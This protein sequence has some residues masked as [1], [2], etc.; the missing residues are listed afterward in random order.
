[1]GVI[2]HIACVASLGLSTLV[3]LTILKSLWVRI[4]EE[5]AYQEIQSLGVLRALKPSTPLRLLKGLVMEE[6]RLVT[7][8]FLCLEIWR[9]SGEMRV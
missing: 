1:M 9:R 4:P 8:N 6:M 7:L 2:W 5:R 3:L